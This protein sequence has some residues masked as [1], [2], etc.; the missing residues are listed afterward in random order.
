MVN[1]IVLRC[2]FYLKLGRCAEA[3][4]V[5]YE[6]VCLLGN[7]ILAVVTW[8]SFVDLIACFMLKIGFRFASLHSF[9]VFVL[10][11]L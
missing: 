3:F 7:A 8:G 1:W 11:Y 4:F 9:W 10:A 6:N 5:V 2:N